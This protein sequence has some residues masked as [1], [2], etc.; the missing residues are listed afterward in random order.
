MRL[1]LIAVGQE[2]NDFNPVPTSMRDYAAFGIYEGE[3]ILRKLGD[4]GQVAGYLQAVQGSGRRVETIPIVRGWAVAGGRIT[5]ECRRYFLD[6]IAAGLKAAGKVDGLALQLH[7]ACAS[8]LEDDVEG[9]QIALCRSIL[10]PRVPIVVS[11]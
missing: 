4:F 2:T 9:E 10:G 1:A 3:E 11:L 6:R 7:G 5:E 8:E